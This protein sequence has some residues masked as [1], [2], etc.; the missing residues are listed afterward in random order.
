MR[1]ALDA[2]SATVHSQ[3][4]ATL[5]AFRSFGHPLLLVAV[6]GALEAAAVAWI[7][8]VPG[9]PSRESARVA[10]LVTAV[11]VVFVGVGSRLAWWLAILVSALGVVVGLGATFVDFGVEGPVA[12]LLH[13]S[14]LWLIWSGNVEL[15]VQSNKRKRLASPTADGEAELHGPGTAAS[16]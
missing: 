14:A 5:R 7:A 1:P 16:Q 9:D 13:A 10:L 11:L 2:P 6:W 3:P 4:V 8:F 12:A 15:Y